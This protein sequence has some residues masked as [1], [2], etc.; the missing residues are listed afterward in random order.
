ML[1]L[2]YQNLQITK[3]RLIIYQRLLRKTRPMNTYGLY[4]QPSDIQN[5]INQY[6]N[7]GFDYT[8]DDNMSADDK[9]ETYWDEAEGVEE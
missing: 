5:Y 7:Y 8:G 2:I 1:V 4:V 6:L 3:I 9:I